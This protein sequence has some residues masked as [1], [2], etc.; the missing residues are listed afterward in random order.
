MAKID[1][2]LIITIFNFL[3]CPIREAYLLSSWCAGSSSGVCSSSTMVL[4]LLIL[5]L[6]KK[7]IT[8]SERLKLCLHFLQSS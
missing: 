7:R 5:G 6:K 1:I 4:N 8:Y 2:L 3:H